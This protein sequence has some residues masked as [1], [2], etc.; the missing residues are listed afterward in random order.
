MGP[1]RRPYRRPEYR[2][3]A[4]GRRRRDQAADVHAD[5]VG[6]TFRRAEC[7]TE[8]GPERCPV[9]RAECRALGG[10][11][12]PAKCRALGRPECGTIGRALGA[13]E[14]RALLRAIDPPKRRASSLP[15]G[16]TQPLEPAPAGW[17]AYRGNAKVP[18]AINYPPDWTVDESR[19]SEGR[20]YF[21]G[22][23]VTQPYRERALGADRHD[24]L[25]EPNGNIDV[26]RDQ[27]FNSRDQAAH[28][29]AGMDITRNN[30][31]S[32]LTFASIGA[33][34]DSR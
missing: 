32:G 16:N 31:F 9:S 10:T 28:P 33:T 19:A 24:R 13:P 20:V 4:D 22:P 29:E 2:R 34:F 25:R 7:R 17:K 18:I 15:V 11:F 27:Y 1:P 21:Y 14:R 8:P 12:H 30:T 6:R 23:G 26:L 3:D 5:P